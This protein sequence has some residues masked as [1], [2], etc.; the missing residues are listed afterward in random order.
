MEVIQHLQPILTI[1][2]MHACKYA[3]LGA[4]IFVTLSALVYCL[5]QIHNINSATA[6]RIN[7]YAW[8]W[9]K[10]SGK[11]KMERKEIIPPLFCRKTQTPNKPHDVIW[12][13]LIISCYLT[14]FTVFI[15]YWITGC[16]LV[17]PLSSTRPWDKV[18]VYSL[19]KTQWEILWESIWGGHSRKGPNYTY[20]ALTFQCPHTGR[21]CWCHWAQDLAA[22]LWCRGNSGSSLRTPTQSHYRWAEACIQWNTTKLYH[23]ISYHIIYRVISY[24]SSTPNKP[25][26]NTQINPV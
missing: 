15:N 5:C 17:Q 22:G 7:R 20:T 26:V 3:C 9:A 13:H 8:Y 4:I 14:I 23:I 10:Q 25:C 1:P 12:F 19:E 6:A 11:W 24:Q 21:R 16:K 2:G 18:Y